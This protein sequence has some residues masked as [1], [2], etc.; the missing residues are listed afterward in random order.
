MGC[1]QALQFRLCE[2]GQ[3]QVKCLIAQQGQLEAQL[4]LIPAS[5]ERQPVVRNSQGA[6]LRFGKMR[7]Y[8]GWYMIELE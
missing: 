1:Q 5:L 3:F 7:Q 6:A 2:A 8:D 4:F